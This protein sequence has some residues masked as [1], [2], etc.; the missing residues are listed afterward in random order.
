MVYSGLVVT[1]VRVGTTLLNNALLKITFEG[2]TN[3][4]L[5][6]ELHGLNREAKARIAVRRL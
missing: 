1:D 3:D 2:D 5:A 4:I 6:G